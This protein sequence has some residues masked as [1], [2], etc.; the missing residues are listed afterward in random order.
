MRL[1]STSSGASNTGRMRAKSGA[2]SM[3][4]LSEAVR[5]RRAVVNWPKALLKAAKAATSMGWAPPGGNRQHADGAQDGQARGGDR[6]VGSKTSRPGIVG[7]LLREGGTMTG[8]APE[9]TSS[10][11]RRVPTASRP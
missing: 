3:E 7:A 2:A 5:L 8:N 4:T 1:S 11:S 10:I 9:S 6:L